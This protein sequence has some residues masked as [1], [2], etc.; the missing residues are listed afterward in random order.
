[1]SVQFFSFQITQDMI[2]CKEF[3]KLTK[4]GYLYTGLNMD[5]KLWIVRGGRNGSFEAL[6]VA[7]CTV[8]CK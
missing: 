7:T 8:F 6:S 4:T 5:C 3:I 1:M 2:I